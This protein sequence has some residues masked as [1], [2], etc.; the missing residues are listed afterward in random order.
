MSSAP[1]T[2]DNFVSIPA[3]LIVSSLE[4]MEG[5]S[6]VGGEF[7]YEIKNFSAEIKRRHHVT[8]NVNMGQ[9]KKFIFPRENGKI[10]RKIFKM[11]KSAFRRKIKSNM[12]IE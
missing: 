8:Q 2:E 9:T 10:N 7:L 6:N 1:R 12:V 3:T 4:R 5:T 11:S